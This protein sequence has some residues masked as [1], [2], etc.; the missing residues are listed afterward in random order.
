MFMSALCCQLAA[1]PED[2]QAPLEAGDDADAVRWMPVK[3]LRFLPGMRWPLCAGIYLLIIP[4]T[5]MSV[6]LVCRRF[7][8]WLHRDR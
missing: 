4:L 6:C 8:A 7:D 1:V 3:D 2:P 5:L